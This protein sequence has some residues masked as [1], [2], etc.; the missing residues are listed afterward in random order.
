M[1]LEVT[2]KS[3]KLDAQATKE[4]KSMVGATNESVWKKTPMKWMRSTT[5]EMV[6]KMQTNDDNIKYNT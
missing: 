5:K 2:K 6:Q 1:S 4:K 3:S